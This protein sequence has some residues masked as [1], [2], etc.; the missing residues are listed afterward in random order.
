V[1]TFKHKPEQSN[2]ALAVEVLRI[3]AA[4]YGL[5]AAPAQTSNRAARLAA[6]IAVTLAL[7][8]PA[9]AAH[10]TGDH[11]EIVGGNPGTLP[12]VAL[13]DWTTPSYTDTCT[14]TVVATNIVLTAGHC[15]TGRA[16]TYRVTVQPTTTPVTLRVSQ[17]ISDPEYAPAD[18][19]AY[20]AAVLVL[21]GTTSAPPIQLAASELPAGTPAIITGYGET[22]PGSGPSPAAMWAPTVIQSDTYCAAVWGA[23][24]APSAMCAVNAPAFDTST[25]EGD[26]GGPL[27]ISVNGQPVEVGITDLVGVGYPTN[28]PQIFTRIDLVQP[29]VEAEIAANPPPV[30]HTVPRLHGRTLGQVRTILRADSLKLGN[31]R[32]TAGAGVR[33]GR[34]IRQTPSPGSTQPVGTSVNVWV[35]R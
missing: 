12:A 30:T 31:V 2:G 6:A 29:W 24:L 27:A 19:Y 11:P 15:A 25:G 4:H 16:S 32:Q 5:G 33:V 14:G 3:L 23:E 34:V 22:Y 18:D 26:S 35:R 8:A 9:A 10:P 13:V 28:L 7:T 21:D 17:V 20:D 1:F